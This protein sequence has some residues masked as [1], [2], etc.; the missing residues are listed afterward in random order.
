M[1]RHFQRGGN[2]SDFLSGGFA[3]H[4]QLIWRDAGSIGGFTLS[5]SFKLNFNSFKRLLLLIRFTFKP[6]NFALLNC[7]LSHTSLENYTT[8]EEINIKPFHY[9]WVGC[10]VNIL[11]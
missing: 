2:G 11:N 4:V 6:W 5:A 7:L 10:T 3:T 9:K 1:S 8:N